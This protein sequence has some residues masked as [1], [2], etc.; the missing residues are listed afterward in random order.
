MKFL[1]KVKA[2]VNCSPTTGLSGK[3]L[4]IVAMVMFQE[5]LL[6]IGE[7]FISYSCRCDTNVKQAVQKLNARASL[8]GVPALACP[9][10]SI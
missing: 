9:H 5:L 10:K 7:G 4:N 6:E 2:N 1:E 3:V 8:I